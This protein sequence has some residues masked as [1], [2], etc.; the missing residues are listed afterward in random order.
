MAGT[1]T[2]SN[3]CRCKRC[4]IV[5]TDTTVN[6]IR[7]NCPVVACNTCDCLFWLRPDYDATPPPFP[8]DSPT[9][10]AGFLIPE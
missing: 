7:Q 9:E 4:R 3:D 1:V 8:L 10:G 5:V 2:L 6:G